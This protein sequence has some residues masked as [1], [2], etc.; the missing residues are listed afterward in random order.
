MAAAALLPSSS[1]GSQEQHS[2]QWDGLCSSCPMQ[3]SAFYADRKHS[4]QRTLLPHRIA[5]DAVQ[6]WHRT[7]R[8]GRNSTALR[9]T[10]RQ[11]HYRSSLDGVAVHELSIL[12]SFSLA[13]PKLDMDL[14]L[15][16]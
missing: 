10:V 9:H 4:T 7:Q 5:K 11:P 3:S 16:A 1:F 2:A 15:P 6:T 14:A 8:T 12:D 13:A